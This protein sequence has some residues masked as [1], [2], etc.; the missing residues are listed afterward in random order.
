MSHLLRL[1]AL[2][3][4]GLLLLACGATDSGPAPTLVDPAE[5]PEATIGASDVETPTP[6]AT[7]EA[8]PEV[9][10]ELGAVALE[11]IAPEVTFN[12]PTDVYAV[13]DAVYFVVEQ[14]GYIYRLEGEESTLFFDFSDTAFF[15]GGEEG[16]LSVTPDPEYADNGHLWMY[17]YAN[18]PNRTVI[19]RFDT[20]ADHSII[21]ESELVIFEVPQPYRNHNGGVIRFGN[22]GMLYVGYGDGGAQRDPDGQGQNLETYLSTIIRIDVSNATP[23]APYQVPEDN[24]FVDV[25]GAQPEIWAYGL[26]NPWRMDFDRET[27]LLWV[28]D[29]GEAQVEEISI[30]LPGANLG[31]SIM[32]GDQCFNPPENCVQEGLTLPVAVYTHETGGCSITGGPVMRGDVSIPGLS[33]HYLFSDFCSG[34]IWALHVSLEEPPIMLTSGAGNVTVFNQVRDEALVLAFGQPLQRLVSAS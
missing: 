13:D 33:G 8:T 3:I 11:P 14:E 22:D 9:R 32:E 16:L 23:E 30:A 18:Q 31:W 20:E 2:T 12:R 28:A 4:V 21:R 7:P 6:T 1:S 5:T 17:Y 25:E 27:G 15:N 24:P 10:E 34:E 29:V 26:R 19:S